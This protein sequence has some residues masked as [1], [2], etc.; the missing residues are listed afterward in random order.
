MFK[1]S[2]FIYILQYYGFAHEIFGVPMVE[3]CDVKEK[4]SNNI[5]FKYLC[6]DIDALC[7]NGKIVLDIS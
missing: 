4:P 2:N 1:F 6:E 3:C 5:L 7:E